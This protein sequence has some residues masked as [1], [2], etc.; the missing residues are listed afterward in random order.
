VAHRRRGKVGRIP[1]QSRKKP[2]QAGKKGKGRGYEK[3]Y[4]Q[5]D[6]G[7]VCRKLSRKKKALTLPVRKKRKQTLPT[8]FEK[9][10]GI[11]GNAKSSIPL[12]AEE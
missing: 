10:R 9:K 2:C 11:K 7:T 3:G 6:K 4:Q 5:Q 1:L 8:S 12:K